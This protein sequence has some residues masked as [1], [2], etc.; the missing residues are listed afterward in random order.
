M[1]SEK[2][3]RFLDKP[4]DIEALGLIP[5]VVQQREDGRV[6]PE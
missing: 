5:G 1:S 6:S 2:Q 3:T 4:E